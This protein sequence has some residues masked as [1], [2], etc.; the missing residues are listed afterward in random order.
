MLV[1][2]LQDVKYPHILSS[3]DCKMIKLDITTATHANSIQP[4]HVVKTIN[5]AL[6]LNN[7]NDPKFEF[8]IM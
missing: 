6:R 5:P 3:V 2:M 7:N 1:Q 4:Q 8:N